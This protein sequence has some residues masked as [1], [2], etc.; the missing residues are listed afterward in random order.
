VYLVV[1]TNM[2]YSCLLLGVAC[3]VVCSGV[4]V[5]GISYME[6]VER[7]VEISIDDDLDGD[8]GQDGHV[9]EVVVQKCLQLPTPVDRSG[10]ADVPWYGYE[11]HPGARHERIAKLLHPEATIGFEIESGKNIV[12]KAIQKD[13]LKVFELDHWVVQF[14]CAGNGPCKLGNFELI[15]YQTNDNRKQYYEAQLDYEKIRKALLEA[16]NFVKVLKQ[17]GS[18]SNNRNDVT[19]KLVFALGQKINCR[20]LTETSK[21]TLENL[22]SNKKK[23]GPKGGDCTFFFPDSKKSAPFYMD[24]LNEPVRYKPQVTF[25]IPLGELYDTLVKSKGDRIFG[26][27]WISDY[28]RVKGMDTPLKR[29]QQRKFR[30]WSLNRVTDPGEIRL[31]QEAFN[32][33]V[34]AEGPV[35]KILNGLI[36]VIRTII[37]QIFVGAYGSDWAKK[38]HGAS[39]WSCEKDNSAMLL[40]T[41][42]AC[43]LSYAFNNLNAGE[44]KT[45]NN[46]LPTAEVLNELVSKHWKWEH[47]KSV[48]SDYNDWAP[49]VNANMKRHFGTSYLFN[50]LSRY[51]IGDGPE[52]TEEE[53]GMLGDRLKTQCSTNKEQNQGSALNYMWMFGDTN[54]VPITTG[55]GVSVIHEARGITEEGFVKLVNELVT[56]SD[57]PDITKALFKL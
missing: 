16:T 21:K 28:E 14:E 46:K 39:S 52:S 15:T 1:L 2:V 57:G 41:P 26:D 49:G 48:L 33:E 22:I 55:S 12:M 4:A 9:A 13:H 18:V 36:I 34:N 53:A 45:L 47:R 27:D 54:G 24:T 43:V 56:W 42:P 8:D 11:Y 40:K 5:G 25:G 50:S 6:N 38:N 51:R 44:R 32:I 23:T 37:T 17:I 29:D 35:A 3:V 20:S 19:P 7:V 31:W 30:Q 10:E